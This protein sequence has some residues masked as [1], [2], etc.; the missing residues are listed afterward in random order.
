MTATQAE[1]GAALLNADLPRPHRISDGRGGPANKR[2]DVYRNNV[3][4]S[5]SDAMEAAF[6]VVRMLV[7]EE[8]FRAMVGLAVRAHPPRT[9]LMAEFGADFPA[10]LEGFP[11][12]AHLPYLA[13]IA[14]IENARRRAYHAA[15]VSGLGAEDVAGWP[16][17][18]FAQAKF[19]LVPCVEVIKSAY[20]IAAIWTKHDPGAE[21]VAAD[22]PQEVLVSRPEFD[23]FVDPLP[24][25]AAVFLDA[26]SQGEPLT[27]AIEAAP[28][29]FDFAQ[30]LAF[31]LERRALRLP[32]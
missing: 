5:L 3:V 6:P 15:D 27:A 1:F 21:S 7:G 10:F 31:L 22:G 11:P 28:E 2:F 20:P 25:G 23:P 14:R 9:P 32:E 4:V 8:F 16:P 13:D 12:V 26:I 24:S 29:N 19:A 30:T 18:D 17:E